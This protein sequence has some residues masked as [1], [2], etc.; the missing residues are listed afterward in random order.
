[1]HCY[2]NL[3]CIAFQVI[4]IVLKPT[5]DQ[6]PASARLMTR[7]AQSLAL[8]LLLCGASAFVRGP[9]N[10]LRSDLRA[11]SLDDLTSVPT[12]L[13]S[14]L[15]IATDLAEELQKYA[16]P[17]SPFN[18]V[19]SLKDFQDAALLLAASAFLLY[20]RRPKG[21]ARNDLIEV[22]KSKV[23][24]D[25]QLGVFAKSFI[26]AGTVL[27]QYPGV[28]RSMEEVFAHSKHRIPYIP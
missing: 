20:D 1:Q 22:G 4:L 11:F 25:N 26:P 8:L 28:L 16:T 18:L 13:S 10:T 27:G 19:P 24:A 14:S 15:A 21:G 17:S 5:G 3:P 7:A 6:I 23:L 12:V 2:S 9:K